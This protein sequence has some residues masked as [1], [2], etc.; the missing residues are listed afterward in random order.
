MDKF[1]EFKPKLDMAEAQI[2]QLDKK[3]KGIIT[4]NKKKY[5][6]F[7]QLRKLPNS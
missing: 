4:S 7:Q 5:F 2:L 1:I 3:V 6:T